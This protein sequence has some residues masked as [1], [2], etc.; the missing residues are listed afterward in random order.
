[1]KTTFALLLALLVGPLV[2]QTPTTAD[3][4][5][6]SPSNLDTQKLDVYLPSCGSAPYPVMLIM[7]GGGWSGGGREAFIGSP[8]TGAI[9]SRCWAVA[10]IS[11]RRLNPA[12]FPSDLN[13]AKAAVRFLR[14]NAGTYSV[15]ANAI[16]AWGK[17]GGGRLA[18][19]LATTAGISFYDGSVGP[20]TGT[21]SAVAAGVAF[22]APLDFTTIYQDARDY[23]GT[24]P[25]GP[26]FAASSDEILGCKPD[27]GTY[28]SCLATATTG[29][30]ALQ[31]NV[32]S[33]PV[34]SYSGTTYCNVMYEHLRLAMNLKAAGAAWGAVT[35]TG[36]GHGGDAYYSSQSW[37]Y[38]FRWLCA[39]GVPSGCTRT[40]R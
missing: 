22:Y 6:A 28:A 14:A 31:V 21:S 40:F 8:I 19:L 11:Y 2:A 18:S 32:G 29:S 3:I 25:C 23:G 35:Y 34:L 27:G 12:M 33:A 30:P 13:D 39:Q 7:D 1:M 24:G 20:H 4:A 15:D 36:F 5:Y 9:L 37:R 17:S 16:V 38:V 26:S 10:A